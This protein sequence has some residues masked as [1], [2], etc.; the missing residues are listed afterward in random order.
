MHILFKGQILGGCQ[1]HT[2][3]GN[4]LY[5]RVI[6]QIDKHYGTVDRTGLFKTLYEE[7][8]FFESNTHG[9]KYNGELLVLT[10]YLCLSGDLSSQLGV[11][12]TGS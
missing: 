10:P 8:G 3:C 11:G 1:C 2:R 9:G 4:T 5:S 6:S 7:V 12:Q